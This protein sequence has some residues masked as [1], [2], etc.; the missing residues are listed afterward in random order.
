MGSGTG[1]VPDADG[2]SWPDL[3][4][5]LYLMAVREGAGPLAPESGGAEPAGPRRV[6]RHDDTTGALSVPSPSHEQPDGNAAEAERGVPETGPPEHDVSARNA[7]NGRGGFGYRRR[8][9][10]RT[11]AAG[12]VGSVPYPMDSALVS[13]AELLR[14]LRPIKRKVPSNRPDDVELDEPATAERAAETR[15]WQL[16]TRPR[17]SRWLDLTLVIDATPSMALWRP[18]VTRLVALIQSSGVFR[19][20]QQRRLDTAKAGRSEDGTTAGPVLH[21]G[22]PDSPARRPSEILDQSKRRLVLV[23]TDGFGDAWRS[24]LV[25]PVL[26]E[27]AREMPVAILHLLPERMWDRDGPEL[28]RSELTVHKPLEP[29]GGYR[30]KLTDEWVDPPRYAELAENAIPIPVLE[31][32]PRWLH[33]W[34]A[35]IAKGGRDLAARVYLA[36]EKPVPPREEEWPDPVIPP[37]YERVKLFRSIAS[38]PAYRLAT[39]LAAVPVDVGTARHLQKKLVPGS[40]PAHLAEVFTSGLLQQPRSGI[41]WDVAR[42]EIPM[43][44]RAHLLS[45]ARRSETAEAIEAAYR[46]SG[47]NDP[48]LARLREAVAEPDSTVDPETTVVGAGEVDLQRVVMSAMSGPYASRAARLA[49]QVGAE[50][51]VTRATSSIVDPSR[52]EPVSETMAPASERAPSTSNPPEAVPQDVDPPGG[53]AN[54]RTVQALVGVEETE[55]HPRRPAD[56]APPVWG[57]I[58]PRNSNFTG[59]GE[60]LDQLAKRLEAGT[61]AVLPAALHGMGGIGKTQMAVEYIYRHLPDY[62]IVWWIQATQPTQ[63]RKSLTEL[64]QR[65]KLPN[66]DEAITAVPAVREALRRGRPHDRWLLVFDSAEDPDT[67]RAFF[68]QGGK[69]HILV[70]SRNPDWAGIARPLEVAVFRRAESKQLLGRRGPVLDDADADRISSKLGDL[71]LAVEQAAAWL[72]ETGMSAT[73]YLELFDSKVAEL[74][75]TAAPRD[76]EL[77]VAAAWNVSFDELK[78][79]SPAAHQLLQVCA[80]FAPEPIARS[81]FSGVRGVSVAPDL[82]AALRDPIRL[83]RAVRDINRYGLAKIDHRADTLLLHRLVQLVL[84]NRMD[85]R[86]SIEIRHGAHQLLANLDPNDPASPR[87]WP[88]YQEI[89]PHIYEADLARCNDPWVRQLVVNLL[90]FLYHWGDHQGALALA[91]HA[92]TVWEQDRRE[93]AARNEPLSEDQLLR[94]LEASERLAFYQWVVGRY[95]DAADTIDRTLASYNETLGSDREETLNA[96]VTN[97]LILKANGKFADARRLNEEV[98]T[99]ASNLFG[100]EEPI[101]LN[102]AH[103]CVVSRLLTG[104]YQAARALA[105]QTYERRIQVFGYDNDATLSTQ[106]LLVIARRELGDYPWARVEQEHITK[107][108]L[109]FYGR[110]SVG[111]L[112][113]QYHHSVA[114]RKDGDHKQALALSAEALRLFRIRYGNTHPSTM[115]CALGQSI[116]LRHARE[117]AEARRLGEEVFDLYRESVGENHPHTLSA[118]VDL[119]VTM[120]LSGDPTSA[121]K[122]D[123]K[124]LGKL[125]EALGEDHPHTIVCG[126]NVAS[127]LFALDRIEEAAEI[128]ADLVERATRVLGPE[129]PTSLAVRLNRSLDLR[130]LGRTEEAD[131]LFE[132]VK[133]GYRQTLGSAHPGTRAAAVGIRADC[134]IDPM[135]L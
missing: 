54:Q 94:E 18:T 100:P 93:R 59:R 104:D 134:D 72:A 126:I 133:S 119:A 96:Q 128:D 49:G 78:T 107:R 29:N 41:A 101:T 111:T 129:H 19:S 8:A 109:S 50:V 34:S 4:D 17:R 113:R 14:A 43:Q 30:L 53:E 36:R 68:P 3:A 98:L 135:P 26:A 20:V 125:R 82:D 60:L 46:H 52:I 44:V 84:R 74:L 9:E 37:A 77:S 66:S 51:D 28:H 1:G 32:S 87:H 89:L 69:G 131:E 108:A 76:Y 81:L 117:F 105:E 92:V 121:R 42:W 99:K 88:R 112:R 91:E 95:T 122:L 22:T 10:R 73:Q 97:A 102:A 90:R 132:A 16:V 120:R 55:R 127:D 27:W 33:W 39:L 13:T 5:A 6:P 2:L 124:A 61:T 123:V 48:G 103:D 15:E 38:P 110:E 31:L 114:C 11:G 57:M 7:V 83:A 24:D 63:I 115:A 35:M 45:G 86:H 65:L 116:D 21:G 25:S 67:V 130:A 85:E 70:T 64:A 23:L 71:P 40:E 118:A 79:R 106:V 75:D 80:F 56:E 47:D 12:S 58:P 62:D